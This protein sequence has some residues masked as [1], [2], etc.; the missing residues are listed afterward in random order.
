MEIWKEIKDYK[1]LYEISNLGNVKGIKRN[2]IKKQSL[3]KGYKQVNLCKDGLVKTHPIHQLLSVAFLNHERCGHK[4]VVDHI[5]GNKENNN[6]LNLQ[7]I[8]QRE[9][10]SKSK[11]NKFTGATFLKKSGKWISR[12]RIKEKYKYLGVFK[13]QQEAH[14]RYLLEANQPIQKPEPPLY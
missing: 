4:I 2:I 5:D 10:T 6:I 9:N 13:T 1:G 12:I 7:L 11:S 14:E 8:T 3:N